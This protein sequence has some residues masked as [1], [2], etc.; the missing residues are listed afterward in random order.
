[1][2][3]LWETRNKKQS[4]WQWTFWVEKMI[5]FLSTKLS[6]E[7]TAVSCTEDTPFIRP[8]KNF[9]LA[10][11]I[12]FQASPSKF[13][14]SYS[15]E[16]FKS[17]A[18]FVSKIKLPHALSEKLTHFFC[19]QIRTAWIAQ[20]GLFFSQSYFDVHPL[21]HNY[22]LWITTKSRQK[23]VDLLLLCSKCWRIHWYEHTRCFCP[24]LFCISMRQDNSPGRIAQDCDHC[25][26]VWLSRAQLFCRWPLLVKTKSG[27]K[28]QA[29]QR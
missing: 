15:E 18:W 20:F 29:N 14:K 4:W 7:V 28:K 25:P 21:K 5:W 3:P 6:G 8:C 11:Q 10:I 9:F 23:F 17:S 27:C 2:I 22:Y 24:H 16:H 1:M 26:L 12:Q 13:Q 19:N